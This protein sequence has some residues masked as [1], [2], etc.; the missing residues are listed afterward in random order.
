MQKTL[1]RNPRHVLREKWRPLIFDRD[2]YRCRA[3]G[4]NGSLELA[5]I[6]PVEVMSDTY[7][8]TG[9][10]WSFSWDNLVT[11]CREC[12]KCYHRSKR[13]F[14]YSLKSW[15][16]Q[17]IKAVNKLFFKLKQDRNQKFWGR[18]GG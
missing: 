5:H 18:V 13:G 8:Y 2:I 7:G 10:E 17:K 11:L 9:V 1:D 12:H 16:D 4:S 14:N 15:Q 3:C 6:T